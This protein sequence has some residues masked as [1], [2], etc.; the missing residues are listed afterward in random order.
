MPILMRRASGRVGVDGAAAVSVRGAASPALFPGADAAHKRGAA[1]EP[2]DPA[3]ARRRPGRAIVMVMIDLHAHT[4]YSDGTL[5]PRELV[6]LAA[7]IGLKAV[8]VTDHDTIDGLDEALAAGA[9]LG[10]EVVPGVEI[11]LEH[12]RLTVDLLGYF[13]GRP[14]GRRVCRARSPSCAATA[15]SATRRSSSA[16][17]SSATRSSPTSSP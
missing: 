16:C 15:T 3:D 8:A 6:R 9:E 14:A 10:V 13:P 11:N 4:T 7:R 1:V 17:A 5:T 12:D 2:R